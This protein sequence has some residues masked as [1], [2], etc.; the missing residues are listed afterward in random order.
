[1]RKS[2]EA[3][4]R[5]LKKWKVKINHNKTQA[6][7]FPFNKSPKRNPTQLLTIDGSV[8]PLKNSVRYLGITLDKKL[9][10]KEHITDIA[11]KALKCGRALYPLTNKRS[12]LSNNNKI[13]LYNMCIRPIMSY[14]CQ[15]WYKM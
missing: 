6:I 11:D 14:G 2:L 10:F 9:N 5:Y 1:M 8:I 13:R 7:I 3:S 4:Q 12:L 15:I